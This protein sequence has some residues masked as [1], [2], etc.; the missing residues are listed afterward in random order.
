MCVCV[1]VCVCV[2]E[3]FNYVSAFKINCDRKWPNLFPVTSRVS[4]GIFRCWG[5]GVGRQL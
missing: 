1:C 3:Y 4:Y 5:G 2:C